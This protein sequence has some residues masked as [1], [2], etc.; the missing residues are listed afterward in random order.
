MNMSDGLTMKIIL[1]N[2]ERAGNQLLI[3]GFNYNILTA[4]MLPFT[5]RKAI[6]VFRLSIGRVFFLYSINPCYFCPFR[7]F[8]VFLCVKN[9]GTP[10]MHVSVRRCFVAIFHANNNLRYIRCGSSRG[11]IGLVC[12]IG[13]VRLG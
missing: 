6:L 12:R 11:H 8:T 7:I 13:R 5:I 10:Y 1:S 3:K 9:D 2:W 4:E